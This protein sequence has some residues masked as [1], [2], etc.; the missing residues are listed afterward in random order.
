MDTE[1]GRA[2]S[3]SEESML[4]HL[5][6]RLRERIRQEPLSSAGIAAAAG[7]V[8]GWGMANRTVLLALK[9]SAALALQT[10]VIPVL[11]KRLKEHWLHDV[12]GQSQPAG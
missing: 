12:D 3:S 4:D 10:I 5:Q 2:S 7:F 9:A 1:P 11:V 8:L 6:D